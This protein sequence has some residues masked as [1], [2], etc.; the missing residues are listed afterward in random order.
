VRERLREQLKRDEGA[1]V[2]HGRVLIYTDTVGK[3]TG[4][5]GRNLTDRGLSLAEA[6]LLLEHDIDDAIKDC[7]AVVPGFTGLDPAR[8]AV[9]VNMCF[10]LGAVK[11]LQFTRT[12]KLIEHGDYGKAADAMLQSKWARQVGQRAVRLANQMRTGVW[13]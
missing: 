10:N 3:V 7:V 8:Q 4:G 13:T 11:L 9:V 5:Y 6:E 1:K 2:R 12:L